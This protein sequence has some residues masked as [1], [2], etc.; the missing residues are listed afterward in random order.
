MTITIFYTSRKD[1]S[2]KSRRKKKGA[3]VKKF[4]TMAPEKQK[5]H[6]E[7]LSICPW[8]SFL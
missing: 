8:L 7:H 2:E 6:G 3:M 1:A 5:S 4:A